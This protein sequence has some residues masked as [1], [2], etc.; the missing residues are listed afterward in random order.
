MW[1]NPKKN[2]VSG[3]KPPMDSSTSGERKNV[4]MEN[5][6]AEQQAGINISYENSFT[7]IKRDIMKETVDKKNGRA[8]KLAINLLQFEPINEKPGANT[9]RTKT[10]TSNTSKVS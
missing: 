5:S 3:K 8:A 10:S 7:A 1:S 4:L 9:G 2:P 6:R